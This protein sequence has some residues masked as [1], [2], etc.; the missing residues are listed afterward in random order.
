MLGRKDHDEL[1]YAADD[2]LGG[3]PLFIDARGRGQEGDSF[4]VE[5]GFHVVEAVDAAKNFLFHTDLLPVLI[6]VLMI[7]S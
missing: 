6:Y 4:A 1:S 5:Q 2:G 3:D 7:F